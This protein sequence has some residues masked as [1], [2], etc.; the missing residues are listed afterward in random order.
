MTFNS[1]PD[2][3]DLPLRGGL[4]CS[5]GVW[6]ERDVFGCLNLLS[7]E[8]ILMA[9]D[10]VKKGSVFSLNWDV[11]LPDPPLFGRSQ[12]RHE[13]RSNTG[14][15][16]QDDQLQDWN[17]QGSSQWDGFRHVRREGHGHYNGVADAEHGVHHWARRGIVGRG[18]LVDLSRWRESIGKPIRQDAPDPIHG[19][20]I[21]A[22]ARAQDTEI[23]RGDILLL[24]TG[25]VD[26]YMRLDSRDRGRIKKAETLFSPGLLANEDTARTLWNLHI[27]AV[28]ADNP[29][30]E[31]WPLGWQLNAAEREAIAADPE[32]REHE[33]LLHTYL[34]PMLGLPIGE[35]FALDSLAEDCAADG[36]YTCLFTSAPIN[37]SAGVAS[38]PN[39]LAIK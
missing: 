28:A 37:L 30:L 35:L 1:V 4:R 26:W 25:W 14:S 18:V 29:A 33:M 8:R 23:Q 38:P 27:A 9:S 5:W 19:D 32:G 2:Y 22:A 20:E 17:T 12:P 31:V 15:R 10:E 3:D 6:G 34:L 21:L 36:R 16:S 39:A 7:N 13:I 24:R 11:M